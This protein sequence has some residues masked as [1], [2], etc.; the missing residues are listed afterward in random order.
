MPEV[1][2][3]VDPSLPE[4]PEAPEARTVRLS[5]FEAFIACL[6]TSV[7]RIRAE[8]T[9]I[10]ERKQRQISSTL[11]SAL[12][13]HFGMT[14]RHLGLPE[15]RSDVL[16]LRQVTVANLDILNPALLAGVQAI[17]TAA[18]LPP[19]NS[20]CIWFTHVNAAAQKLFGD[21]SPQA[22]QVSRYMRAPTEECKHRQ[23]FARAGVTE[24][25]RFS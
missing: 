5:V 10:G 21:G 4:A 16:C 25:N 1:L 7:S 14:L 23:R 9:P 20:L 2:T 18:H 6:E 15:Y 12:D 13:V 11:S 8:I 17:V 19:F 24:R 22:E 3:L